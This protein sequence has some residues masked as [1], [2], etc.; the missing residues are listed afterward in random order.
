[1]TALLL[2]GLLL[3]TPA[4][5]DI[6]PAAAA[7][8]PKALR[9]IPAGTVIPVNLTSRISTKH[10]KEGDGIYAQTA[11]PIV[12]DNVI[13]IPAGSF[14]RGKVA[15]VKQPGR[16]KGRA[17]LTFN[18]QNMTLPSGDTFDIFASLGGTGGSYERKGE[19]TVVR[20]KGEDNE[21]VL[22]DTAKGGGTGA[23][24]GGVYRGAGGAVKGAAIGA[25]AGGAG[26]ALAALIRKGEALILEPGTMIEIVLDRPIEK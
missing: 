6:K 1:M 9:V 13:V 8:A 3:Q 2:I 18:F 20:D 17:E 14:L 25:A 15:H 24:L 7:D 19:A 23:V 10:V 5:T 12:I 16:I 21:D 22:T 11:V 4:Q 26:S